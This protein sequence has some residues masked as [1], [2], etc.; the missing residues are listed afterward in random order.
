MESK[1]ILWSEPDHELKMKVNARNGR[2]GEKNT[3]FK[4]NTSSAPRL[5]EQSFHCN[6]EDTIAMQNTDKLWCR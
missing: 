5:S 3:V 4:S 2:M 1:I 6:D